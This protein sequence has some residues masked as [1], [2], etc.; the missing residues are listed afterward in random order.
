MNMKFK[1]R[2][3]KEL[4]VYNIL[5]LYTLLFHSKRV[6]N[7]K[8]YRNSLITYF[9]TETL[10]TSRG[11]VRRN[12]WGS[13][14]IPEKYKE[15]FNTLVSD[16]GWVFTTP[17]R[18]YGVIGYPSLTIDNP[19]IRV[20]QLDIFNIYYDVNL[21]IQKYRKFNTS[22]DIWL[23]TSSQFSFKNVITEI[24]IWDNYYV[25]M[26]FGKFIGETRINNSIYRIYSGYIDKSNE[27]L[28][29]DGWNYICFMK[30]DRVNTNVI[31]I[32]QILHYLMQ[33]HLIHP[34]LFISRIEFGN[35]VYNAS[36]ELKLN[37]LEYN[38]LTH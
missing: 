31:N 2:Q 24:M 26:P 1:L 34:N 13:F 23:C 27:N 19:G 37:K 7:I 8:D 11:K 28:K 3:L 29:I 9:N 35:E 10:E 4:T 18:N 22:F 32:K 16:I 6:E 12:K 17:I 36:G 21:F 30:V 20:N 25:A 33:K 14:K 5:I 38:L 15:Q